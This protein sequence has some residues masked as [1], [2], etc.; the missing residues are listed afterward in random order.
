MSVFRHIEVP[1]SIYSFP[2]TL[3]RYTNMATYYIGKYVSHV[4]GIDITSY[5]K[6][7]RKENYY[8]NNLYPKNISFESNTDSENSKK[9]N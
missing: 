2:I 3:E 4:E 8:G 7:P 6:Y 1:N 5:I 9:T